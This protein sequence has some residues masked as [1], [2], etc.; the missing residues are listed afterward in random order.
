METYEELSVKLIQ[1][2]K[3]HHEALLA[4]PDG[5]DFHEVEER[6]EPYRKKVSDLSLK[7][8]MIQPCKFESIPTYGDIMELED[9]IDTCKS[10]GFIDYDGHGYYAVDDKRMTNIKILPSDV[11]KGV[12]RKGFSKIVWFNK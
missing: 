9:F 5:L 6:L 11:R 8:R 1:A 4:L 2:E 3:E 12:I 7:A 10:G